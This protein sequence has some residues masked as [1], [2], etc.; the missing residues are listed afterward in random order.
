MFS[1]PSLPQPTPNAR[2]S[3]L[4]LY[5]VVLTF[6]FDSDVEYPCSD[7]VIF[8]DENLVQVFDRIHLPGLLWKIEPVIEL[9][10][11]RF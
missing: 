6:V 3:Y 8:L 7:D 2:A 10:I 4:D 11:G 9:G 1:G 5:D